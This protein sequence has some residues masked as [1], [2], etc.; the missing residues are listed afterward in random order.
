MLNPEIFASLDFAAVSPRSER[1]LLLFHMHVSVQWMT[2][3][4]PGLSRLPRLPSFGVTNPI[5]PHNIAGRN[6][7]RHFFVSSPEIMNSP[8]PL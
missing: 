8:S 2:S 7:L 6:S 3:S 1:N 4:H 5:E